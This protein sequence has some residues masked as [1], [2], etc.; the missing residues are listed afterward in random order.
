MDQELKKLE[1]LANSD[2]ENFVHWR[3][4]GDALNRI[5]SKSDGRTLAEWLELTLTNSAGR[6]LRKKARKALADLGPV[7]LP[8]L[9]DALHSEDT[10][11]RHRAYLA[12]KV[13]QASVNPFVEKLF[14]QFHQE[15]D[16]QCLKIGLRIFQQAPKLPASS[17][18]HFLK[19]LHDP[20]GDIA[21][22]AREVWLRRASDDELL[23]QIIVVPSHME[24]HSLISHAQRKQLDVLAFL[25][26][27][28]D[29]PKYA[30]FMSRIMAS[31]YVVGQYARVRSHSRPEERPRHQAELSAAV[32]FLKTHRH[33]HESA[34]HWIPMLEHRG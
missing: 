31:A 28:L 5:H 23:E 8:G 26:T 16:C 20:N 34:R 32:D 1:R 17:Q 6:K 30:E 19:L 13:C 27:A 29:Q 7:S 9:F 3:R 4:L 21:S 11:V 10:R 15:T 22:L 25:T 33:R 12:L 2:P 24:N 18:A 14:L